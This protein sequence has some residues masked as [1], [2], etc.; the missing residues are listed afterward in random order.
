VKF[1][2]IAFSAAGPKPTPKLFQT[3]DTIRY[4]TV[5]LYALKSGR[6]GQLNLAHGTETK[7]YG[8]TKNRN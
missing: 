3:K 7:K 2:E 4:G 1:D 5:Y 8:K 6:E